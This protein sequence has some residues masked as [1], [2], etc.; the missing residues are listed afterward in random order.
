MPDQFRLP[1]I[2]A[3]TLRQQPSLR[4]ADRLTPTLEGTREGHMGLNLRLGLLALVGFSLW[5]AVAAADTPPPCNR[6]MCRS[7][8]DAQCGSP[9]GE[10]SSSAWSTCSKNVIAACQSGQIVCGGGSTTPPAPP[11]RRRPPPPRPRPHGRRPPPRRRRR[12]RRRPPRPR[13]PRPARPPP[14]RRPAPPR[15]RPPRQR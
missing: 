12:P 4:L 11:P 7:Q 1:V 15:R 10:P 3:R 5:P 6:T 8:I 13:P 2:E 14:P 9:G